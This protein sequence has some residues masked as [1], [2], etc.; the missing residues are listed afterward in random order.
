MVYY[1][2]ALVIVTPPPSW[3]GGWQWHNNGKYNYSSRVQIVLL[4]ALLL[5][6]R[7]VRGTMPQADINMKRS[8]HINIKSILCTFYIHIINIYTHWISYYVTSHHNIFYHFMSL[9]IIWCICKF[10]HIIGWQSITSR[11]IVSVYYG[12][13][14]KHVCNMI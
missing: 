13:S 10:Y 4:L 11:S 5:C 12:T 14:K 6:R 2:F 7:S 1:T 9:Y 3:W 8:I